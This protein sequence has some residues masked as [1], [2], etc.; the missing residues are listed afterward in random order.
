M[1]PSGDLLVTLIFDRG[2]VL[3]SLL[4]PLA[5]CTGMTPGQEK[6]TLGVAIQ[7]LSVEA[8]NPSGWDRAT[9]LLKKEG[10]D[11]YGFCT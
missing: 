3:L 5:Y 9:H 10:V 8:Q 4:R 6:H 7:K 1:S 11:F 2:G